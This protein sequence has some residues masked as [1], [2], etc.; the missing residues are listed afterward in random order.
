MY[1]M[2]ERKLKKTPGSSWLPSLCSNHWVLL[3]FSSSPST[4]F[5]P[6]SQS[7]FAQ[8]CLAFHVDSFLWF[9]PHSIPDTQQ[10]VTTSFLLPFFGDQFQSPLPTPDPT[11]QTCVASVFVVS[12]CRPSPLPSPPPQSAALFICYLQS[13]VH[14]FPTVPLWPCLSFKSGLESFRHVASA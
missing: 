11:S 8:G 14:F 9:S 7:S 4:T 6:T 2:S 5:L 3:P 12:L 10:G 1:R 13:P